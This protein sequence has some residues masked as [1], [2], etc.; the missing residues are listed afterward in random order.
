[1]NF[2]PKIHINKLKR[3]KFT[4]VIY[5]Q[6]VLHAFNDIYN[7]LLDILKLDFFKV[8]KCRGGCQV[9]AWKMS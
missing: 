6:H 2:A 1:M 4:Q 3:G 8:Y 9:A 7:M 5:L